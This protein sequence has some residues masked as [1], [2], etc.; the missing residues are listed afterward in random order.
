MHNLMRAHINTQHNR[1]ETYEEKDSRVFDI[2]N[3]KPQ[4]FSISETTFLFPTPIK[5]CS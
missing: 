5:V 4:A 2:W 3:P 1:K